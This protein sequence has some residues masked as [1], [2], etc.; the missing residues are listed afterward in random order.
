VVLLLGL[1]A[2]IVGAVVLWLV[3]MLINRESDPE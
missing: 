3:V 2:T 1:V